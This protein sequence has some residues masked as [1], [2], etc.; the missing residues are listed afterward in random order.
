VGTIRC[1]EPQV[2]GN[3]L[4]R[5]ENSKLRVDMGLRLHWLEQTTSLQTTDALSFVFLLSIST[6]PSRIPSRVDR[7]L[8]VPSIGIDF[9]R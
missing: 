9:S 7:I 8:P 1:F 2:V 4:L 5:L 3:H 6:A